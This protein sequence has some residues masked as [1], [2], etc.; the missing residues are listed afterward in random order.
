MTKRQL[1]RRIRASRRRSLRKWRRMDTAERATIVAGAVVHVALMG[2]AQVDMCRRPE[3]EIRGPRWLWRLIVLINFVGPV[4]YFTI[5][6]KRPPEPT[7]SE[8][9]AAAIVA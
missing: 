2:L 8:R 4:A 1:Q 6:R 5:G 9:P 7:S 3:S